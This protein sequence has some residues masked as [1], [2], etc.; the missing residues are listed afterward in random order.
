MHLWDPFPPPPDCEGIEA[1]KGN[2]KGVPIYT[3]CFEVT[4]KLHANNHFA[5]H[6]WL[7]L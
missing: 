5:H 6:A 3:E 1:A 2:E 4:L 7:E